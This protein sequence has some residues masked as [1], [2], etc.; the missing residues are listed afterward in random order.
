MRTQLG[1]HERKWTAAMGGE[2]NVTAEDL[3][4]GVNAVIYW[5]LSAADAR[6]VN[7]DEV[8]DLHGVTAALWVPRPRRG[9]EANTTRKH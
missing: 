3:R 7:F 6:V 4:V 2:R 5:N 8:G 1:E 9:E